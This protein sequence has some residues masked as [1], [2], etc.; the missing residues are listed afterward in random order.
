M[1]IVSF[2]LAGILLFCQ[3][4][5]SQITGR[6]LPR[7]I[8]IPGKN[9]ISPSLS[10]DGSLLIYNSNYTFSEKMV[11][12]YTEV[13]NGQ[14]A[15]TKEIDFSQPDKDFVGGHWLTYDSK[16]L[17]MTSKRVPSIGGFDINFSE[18]QGSYF[19]PPQNIGKP[20]NSNKHE[21]HASLTPDG[22][23]LYFMRCETMDNYD[24]DNCE[25]YVA[26]RKTEAYWNEPVKLPYPINTGNEATPRIMPDGETL[27]FA[28]KRTG[29]KGGW[30]LYQSVKQDDDSWSEPIALD[31]LNTAQDEQFASVPAHSNF[32]YYSTINNGNYQ[33]MMAP[34]PQDKKPKKL[35]MIN[36]SLNA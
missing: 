11:L 1:K 24:C 25:I 35:V 31:Y 16:Y 22:K 3:L 19:T 27:I 29:G 21:G 30:D 12:K 34:I 20:I 17:Y 13:K 4:G 6:A 9:H 2:S 28:S 36:G 32:I 33:L 23:Y 7:T 8:N 14:W 18:K 5:Y 15:E 10:A 26:E